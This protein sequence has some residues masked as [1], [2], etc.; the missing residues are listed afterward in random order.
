LK[1]GSLLKSP[2]AQ[3]ARYGRNAP[4][5]NVTGTQNCSP[6]IRHARLTD[7]R[8]LSDCVARLLELKRWA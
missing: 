4:N 3:N 1:T 2:D 5:W 8:I 6:Y 7:Y